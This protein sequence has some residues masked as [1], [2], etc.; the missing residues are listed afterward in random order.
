MEESDEESED[1]EEKEE[2]MEDAGRSTS[3][4]LVSSKNVTLWRLSPFQI[5]NSSDIKR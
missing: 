2:E 1:D 4:H 3:L 5:E